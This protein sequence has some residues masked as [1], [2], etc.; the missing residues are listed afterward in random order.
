[1]Q[2]RHGALV[3]RRV[4]ALRLQGR[5]IVEHSGS[6]HCIRLGS[7]TARQHQTDWVF[8]KSGARCVTTLVWPC[9]D[10]LDQTFEA[11]LRGGGIISGEALIIC[12][13]AKLL[14]VVVVVAVVVDRAGV[15]SAL[16]VALLEESLFVRRR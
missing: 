13:V 15:Y 5:V 14:Q 4:N 8:I 12:V 16:L 1:M 7:L 6:L 9:K 11:R 10:C 3:D 2:G